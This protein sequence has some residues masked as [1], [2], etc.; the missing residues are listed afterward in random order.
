MHEVQSAEV[1]QRCMR[2]YRKYMRKNVSACM[3]LLCDT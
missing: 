3:S 1:Q 2:K